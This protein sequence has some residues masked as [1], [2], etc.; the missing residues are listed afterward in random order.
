MRDR[1]KGRSSLAATVLAVTGAWLLVAW[2]AHARHAPPVTTPAHHAP[3]FKQ[4]HDAMRAA[5]AEV[6]FEPPEPLPERQSKRTDP[7]GNATKVLGSS[8][9]FSGGSISH[10]YRSDVSWTELR[11][12]SL[13]RTKP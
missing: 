10:G 7:Y 13:L 4:M 3:Q 2:W 9:G 6:Q 5:A 1:R 12:M 8:L 11:P